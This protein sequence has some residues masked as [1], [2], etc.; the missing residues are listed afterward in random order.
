MPDQTDGPPTAQVVEENVPFDRYELDELVREIGGYLAEL[1]HIDLFLDYSAAYFDG[2]HAEEPDEDTNAYYELQV[3]LGETYPFYRILPVYSAYSIE[4]EREVHQLADDAAAWAS[5]RMTELYAMIRPIAF[6]LVSGHDSLIGEIQ[7]VQSNLSLVHSDFGDLANNLNDWKGDAAE[8]F[9]D[10][11]YGR[12][13]DALGNQRAV[14]ME[15]FG[16]LAVS[17]GIINYSQQSLMNAVTH[18]RGALREQLLQRSQDIEA[19]SLKE[20]LSVASNVVGAAGLILT[21][22]PPLGIPLDAAGAILGVAAM[23]LPDESALLRI[24]GRSAEEL[25]TSLLGALAETMTYIDRS[26]D[27]LRQRLHGVGNQ[28]GK[29][30]DRELLL[31]SR[32]DLANG[33]SG[34]DFHH[35]TSERYTG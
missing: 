27:E 9:A 13:P 5:D 8:N 17:K 19:P 32:P 20:F 28:V 10:N 16:A 11:F 14:L 34:D 33:V 4:V 35:V 23:V 21:G 6:P 31:P 15:L 3:Q 1:Q 7:T 12:F 18:T 2:P 24:E 30:L 25:A 26:Y 22:Y 29:L